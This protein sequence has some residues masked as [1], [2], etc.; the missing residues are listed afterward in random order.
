MADHIHTL[1]AAADAV[2]AALAGCRD[3]EPTGLKHGQFGFDLAADAAA[4]DV[5]RRAGLRVLSEESG[6][7]RGDGPVAV[8]DPVDGSTNASRGIR[9]FATSICVVD[10]QGPLAAVVHDHGSGERFEALRGGG[11]RCD[12]ETLRPPAPR[13]LAESVV[14]VN[15]WPPG[16]GGWAQYRTLGA[17]AL[18]LCAVAAGR[19]DGYLDFSASGLGSW[20][21]L[22]ALLV[23][24]ETGVEAHDGLGR[25]LVVLDHHSRRAPVAA[26]PPLAADLL[27]VWASLSEPAAAD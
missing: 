11:A 4:T 7:E 26:P 9:Y 17:A 3:W 20:D 1:N 19:L 6:L 25:D 27:A 18:E 8:L 23:C 2:D 15:G 22:G 16:R 13:P 14:G 5:L 24:A 21:Y 12:G 10:A